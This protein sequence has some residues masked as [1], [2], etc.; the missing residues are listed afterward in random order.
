MSKLFSW[1]ISS[2][3]NFLPITNILHQFENRK[4]RCEMFC[5]VSAQQIMGQGIYP[6]VQQFE[7]FRQTIPGNHCHQISAFG[8]SGIKKDENHRDDQDGQKLNQRIGPKIAMASGFGDA[9]INHAADSH[10]Q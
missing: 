10:R 2:E 5:A 7:N 3:S 6:I 8:V 9:P 4:R 1:T